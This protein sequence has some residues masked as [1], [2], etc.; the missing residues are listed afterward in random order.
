[1]LPDI[2]YEYYFFGSK[3]SLDIDVLVNHPNAT[4]LEKDRLLIPELKA[5]SN[6]IEDWN[7]NI[8]KI[9]EGIVKFSIPS[10]GSPD[11]VNNSLYETYHL[12]TQKHPFPIKFKVERNLLSAIHKCL[13][14]ILTFY[15]GT[16]HEDF[17]NAMPRAVLVDKQKTFSDRV[18]TLAQFDFENMRPS[19]DELENIEKYKKI[20]FHIAQTISLIDG[21]EIYTK[22]ELIKYHPELLE[23]INRTPNSSLKP[24]NEKLNILREKILVLNIQEETDFKIRLRKWELQYKIK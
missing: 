21:I 5:K 17:Y 15:K 23:I 8:V 19:L 2:E 6:L 13:E 1:M 14:A 10:K 24:L 12:H 18:H 22:Q 3:D 11:S 16:E 9:E 7:V 4:G 20:G